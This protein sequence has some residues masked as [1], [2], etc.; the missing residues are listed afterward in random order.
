VK[1]F[2]KLL[3]YFG[4]FAGTEHTA[5]DSSYK[6]WVVIGVT[7]FNVSNRTAEEKERE[8]DRE[9][10]KKRRNDRENRHGEKYNTLK[11]R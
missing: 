5:R 6:S 3:L 2:N 7:L 1:R 10:K 8:R 4:H 11:H 9:E